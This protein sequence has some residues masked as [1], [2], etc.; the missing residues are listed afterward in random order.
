MGR[1]CSDK[2]SKLLFEDHCETFQSKA[3]VNYFCCF[4]EISNQELTML[5]SDEL[6]SDG[7]SKRFWDPD[8]SSEMRLLLFPLLLA[9]T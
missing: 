6:S 5:I 7:L 3:K 9:S 1:G 8:F 4:G 2:G